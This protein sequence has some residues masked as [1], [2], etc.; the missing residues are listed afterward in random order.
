MKHILFLE[1]HLV[2]DQSPW[3]RRAVLSAVCLLVIGI[4]VWSSNSGIIE[5]ECSSAKET[6]YNLLVDGFRAGQLNVKRDIPP[7]LARITDPNDPVLGNPHLWTERYY[8]HDLSYYKGKLYLYFGPVPALLLFWPYLILTGHYLLHRDAA[9]IFFSAGFLIEVGL[10]YAI[11]RRYFKEISIW[12]VMAGALALG[13]ANFAPAI[14]GECDVYEVAI[15]CGYMLIMLVLA[16]I[17]HALHD[18]EHRWQWVA[19]ASLAYGLA[20]GARPSLLFG[21]AVLLIPVIQ[22]WREKR[23][24]WPLLLAAGGPIGL[25][26]TGLMCYNVLRFDNPLE[27]GQSYQLP[28]TI[29]HQF[30]LHYFWFNFRVGFLAPASWSGRF[31]FVHDIP[32]PPYPQ[33]YFIVNHP[34]GI[35]ANIPLVWLALAVPLAWQNRTGNERLVLGW[36]LMAIV[37]LFGTCA[38]I[39]CFHDS[40]CLRYEMEYAFPLVLLAVIGVLSLERALAGQWVWLWIA[41]C[42]WGSLLAFSIA[43]NLFACLDF[44]QEVYGNVGV[45]LSYKGEV[46]EAIVQFNKELQI[47]PNAADAYNN[48][49]GV[50]LQKGEVDEAIVQFKKALEIAPNF[51]EAHNNLGWA[52]LDKGQIGQAVEEYKKS[53]QIDPNDAITCKNLGIALIKEG[54]PEAAIPQLQKALRLNPSDTE[55][56]NNLAKAEEIIRQKAGQK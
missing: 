25:I 27:F 22:A 47:N 33:G 31:P 9:V 49:G 20:L 6:Y 45:A 38:G 17:W 32:L 36:F 55:A 44:Q 56:Q 51:A 4:Y 28:V 1:P 2:G 26:G 18:S 3:I 7:E 21:T 5:S 15:S 23:T 35:L 13:L 39:M 37:P 8:L 19:T 42:V 30:S 43:F 41:R 54:R 46:D 24:V 40:M 34:F 53:L 11:W 29:H 10:L 50:F 14:L 12:I 52:L 16:G 48:L